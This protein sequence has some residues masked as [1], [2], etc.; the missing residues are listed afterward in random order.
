M[1]TISFPQFANSLKKNFTKGRSKEYAK[2]SSLLWNKFSE[3]SYIRSHEEKQRWTTALLNSSTGAS[4]HRTAIT[5]HTAID[6]Y[7]KEPLLERGM[8]DCLR[9]IANFTCC[10]CAT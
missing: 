4:T 3:G 10:R 5:E 1:N 2:L 9:L 7:G 8:I 6:M